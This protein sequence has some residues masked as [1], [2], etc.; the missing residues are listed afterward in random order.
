MN[1]A[2]SNLNTGQDI[3]QSLALPKCL[4][5]RYVALFGNEGN[6]KDI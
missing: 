5:F 1:R 6:S 2:V 3:D 4:G